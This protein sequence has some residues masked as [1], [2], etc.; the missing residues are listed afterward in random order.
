MSEPQTPVMRS[1]AP[2]SPPA[3]S[4]VRRRWQ[5]ISYAALGSLLREH[6]AG[7]CHARHVMPFPREVF[8]VQEDFQ[9]G[10]V[11]QR[12]LF[13]DTFLDFEP[14]SDGRLRDVIT[15]EADYLIAMRRKTGV[16]GWAYF[17]GLSELPPDADD[18][19]QVM[20]VLLRAGYR[21]EAAPL[22]EVPLHVLLAEGANDDNGWESWIVPRNH[23]T[24]EQ[25]L[26]TAWIHR[27]WGTG[28]DIEVVANLVFAL[29]IYDQE[30]FAAAIDRGIRF[31]LD[32]HE[33]RYCWKS[34]W[35]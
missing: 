29:T 27:A 22:I 34:N 20:Q 4:S 6:A 18:L 8:R 32:S 12:A 35:Y 33:N 24:E 7:Y 31:L 26:Q 9:T 30:R 25:Q 1:P 17:P 5:E 23:P 19:A 28:S 16:G 21:K 15:A 11:F 10:D 13:L 3:T 2:S 14:V